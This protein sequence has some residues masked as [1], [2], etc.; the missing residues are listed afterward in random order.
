MIY[1]I[2]K[3]VILQINHSIYLSHQIHR[4]HRDDYDGMQMMGMIEKKS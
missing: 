4:K 3:I 2:V 1:W